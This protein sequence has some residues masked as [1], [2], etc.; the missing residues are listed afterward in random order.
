MWRIL[1]RK[2]T[3]IGS[4]ALVLMSM[5]LTSRV[6]GLMR[7]RLLA[8]RFNP[9]E[10]GVYFAAFRIPNL[11]FELLVMGTLTTAFIP[12]FT[13]YI[14]KNQEKESWRMASTII[15]FVFVILTIVSIPVVIFAP[16][17]SQLLA[18][19]FSDEQITQMASF[20]QIMIFFQVIPLMIGN[21]FTGILQSYQLFLI[22]AFAPVIYNIGIIF[23]IYMFS[24][25]LGLYAPVLGVV[26]GAILFMLIQIPLLIRVGYRHMPVIDLKERGVRDV[27]RL[28]G[29]RTLGLA[30]SQIDTT[31]D[32]VLAT[33]MGSRMVTIFNFAQHLQQLPI[34]L[35]GATVAQAA[36]PTLAAAAIS[37]E[38]TKTFQKNVISAQ[39]QILFFILP[40]SVLF[41]VLRIPVVRLVFGSSLF[42]WQ[43]TILT[44]Y[45]LS[46]FSISLFAQSLLQ[47]LVRA[48]YAL[49]DSMT[50]VIV[51]V[52]SI[53]L[54]TSLSILFV[55]VYHYPVWSLGLSTSIASIVQVVILYVLL[56]KR[57]GWNT[58][59]LSML[60]TPIKMTIATA[61]MGF[62]LYVPLKLLDQLVF[63]TT[64]TINLIM[65]TGVTSF[66]GLSTYIFLSWVFNISEV[67]SFVK[68]LRKV[69]AAGSILMEPAQEVV[70]GEQ[71]TVS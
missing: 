34:G 40:V 70:N 56:Q 22:P 58:S 64:R 48:F 19:G 27:F 8:S 3:S 65:L 26:V 4:A 47:V 71:T 54:N 35:F 9:D 55:V 30:V 38:D 45:T 63:D 29:P 59:V 6:L 28:I 46:A 11:F 36:L 21:F 61:I 20:T 1:S 10:L 50:P 18:P 31:V 5:V 23:C 42:D 49:Y 25:S 43:A 44:G 66:I 68:L 17:I 16:V 69:R 24:G 53:L 67:H 39:N 60:I 15:N 52:I 13:K 57:L 33:L 51:G 62:M 14:T 12:V 2:Q 32:L 37:K 7:D 41:I